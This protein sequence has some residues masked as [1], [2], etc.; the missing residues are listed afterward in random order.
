MSAYQFTQIVWKGKAT[1]KVGFGINGINVYAWYCP[2]GNDPDQ[3]ASFKENVCEAACTKWCVTDTVNKCY[4]EKA[5]KK[6]NTYREYHGAGKV[7][8]SHDIAKAAQKKLEGVIN[9]G[10]G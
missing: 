6:H 3:A 2:T 5:I 7:T 9:C 1:K 10:S 4:N 8:F